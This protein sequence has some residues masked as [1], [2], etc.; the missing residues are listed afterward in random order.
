M[1]L[2][3]ATT[4]ACVVLGGC[5]SVRTAAPGSSTARAPVA[6]AKGGEGHTPA[7]IPSPVYDRDL[8][9]VHDAAVH[10]CIDY[11]GHV[12]RDEPAALEVH[13]W[14]FWGGGS[15]VTS[16]TL[17]AT[18]PGRTLVEVE[19]HGVFPAGLVVVAG[20]RQRYIIAEVLR[21]LDAEMRKAPDVSAAR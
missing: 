4:L 2:L 9:A 10:A 16:L 5:T 8:A 6:G 17:S 21:R 14:C 15:T 3:L 1:R 12:D 20:S 7:D 11:F 18:A 19:S 13:D